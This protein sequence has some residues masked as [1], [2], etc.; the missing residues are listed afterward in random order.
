MVAIADQPVLT[1][2]RRIATAQGAV[3]VFRAF[4]SRSLRQFGPAAP[5]RGAQPCRPDPHAGQGHFQICYLL[6]EVPDGGLGVFR[7]GPCP[8]ALLF[9]RSKLV[10]HAI[11]IHGIIV[12]RDLHVPSYRSERRSSGVYS[13]FAH[14][15]GNGM[16]RLFHIEQ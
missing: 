15:T 14:Q 11:H 1:A 12:S 5:H 7:I 13:A 3:Q 8:F 16:V 10:V 4:H 2:L 6:I 9:S